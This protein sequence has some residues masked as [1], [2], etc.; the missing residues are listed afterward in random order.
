MM[1]APSYDAIA[2]YVTSVERQV[3]LADLCRLDAEGQVVSHL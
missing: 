3:D 1:L 2:D